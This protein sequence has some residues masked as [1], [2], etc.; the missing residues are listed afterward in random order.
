[1]FR[2][3]CFIRERGVQVSL[4]AAQLQQNAQE[5]YRVYHRIAAA[6]RRGVRPSMQHQTSDCWSL[7]IS[8][9]SSVHIRLSV[10]SCSVS[11]GHSCVIRHGSSLIR[12]KDKEHGLSVRSSVVDACAHHTSSNNSTLY[13]IVNNCG[14]ICIVQC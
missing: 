8:P 13:S 7:T 3:I 1:M 4:L 6:S 12:H 14:H 10:P 11:H 2:R 5:D 9:Q